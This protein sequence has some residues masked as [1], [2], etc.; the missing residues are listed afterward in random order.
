MTYK[1][2]YKN[3]VKTVV[4]LHILNGYAICKYYNKYVILLLK[5]PELCLWKYM[6]GGLQLVSFEEVVEGGLSEIGW[7]V[8]KP[9][10]GGYV[11][12]HRW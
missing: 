2:K 3:L 9:Q 1:I 6:S 4:V 11:L 12:Y 8:V 5:R 10:M 7:K